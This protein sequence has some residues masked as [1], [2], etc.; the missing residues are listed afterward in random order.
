[1][2]AAERRRDLRLCPDTDFVVTCVA[3]EPVWRGSPYNLARAIVDL[4][5]RG[6]RLV[7]VGRLRE[8]LPVVVD[9]SAPD[10]TARLR[11]RG[12]VRWTRSLGREGPSFAGISF[13]RILTCFGE[14]LRF[15]A[16]P[17]PDAGAPRGRDPQRRFPRFSPPADGVT[18]LPRG[19]WRALGFA[20][21]AA[22]H[23][24]DLSLGGIHLVCGQPLDPGR[25][26]DLGVDLRRPAV[27]LEGEGE[28]RWCRRD[29][30]RLEPRWHAGVAFRNLQPLSR[31]HLVAAEKLYLGF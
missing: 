20:S 3:D 15:I 31:A 12:R 22:R 2:S 10:G 9:V 19:F 29:T 11:A 8:Q 26:V 25:R 24:F 16:P 18:C 14:R 17:R 4:G 6:A 23:L 28:I 7:T 13:E 27:R 5:P 21:N 30:L 1:M